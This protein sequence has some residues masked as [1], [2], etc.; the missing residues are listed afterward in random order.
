[1]SDGLVPPALSHLTLPVG[2][3]VEHVDPN[4]RFSQFGD[5]RPKTLQNFVVIGYRREHQDWIVVVNP[6]EPV[7]AGALHDVRDAPPEH[8]VVRGPVDSPVEFEI[9]LGAGI[10]VPATVGFLHL[11]NILFKAP[12]L[13]LA[14]LT[15][16][17]IGGE[18]FQ[19]GQDRVS[20]LDLFGGELSDVSRFVC[21]RDDEPLGLK[22]ANGLSYGSAAHS[23][24][25]LQLRLR[26]G[27]SRF[28]LVAENGF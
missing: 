9:K 28:D 4:R 26:E 5:P 11:S 20:F 7:P 3:D 16:C 15:C 22:Q 10:Q 23:K 21:V 24:P 27:G 13:L 18:S 2:P 1:V 6:S 19:A 17:K 8:T 25:F 12:E 14:D